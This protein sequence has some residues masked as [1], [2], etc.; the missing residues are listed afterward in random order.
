M[1]SMNYIS[2]E[3]R[4]GTKA[5]KTRQRKVIM[6]NIKHSHREMN[7]I[8]TKGT[9]TNPDKQDVGR[10]IL[11]IYIHIQR[12]MV[13]ITDPTSDPQPKHGSPSQWL[14]ACAFQL[15]SE[16]PCHTRTRS[17]PPGPVQLPLQHLRTP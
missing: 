17:Q 12:V 13:R 6:R 14:T 11:P 16:T 9:N 1:P 4:K 8:I 15:V 5:K 2:N 7:Q 10:R 3:L